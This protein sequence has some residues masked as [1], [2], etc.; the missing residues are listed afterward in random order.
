MRATTKVDLRMG[1]RPYYPELA[2]LGEALANDLKSGIP[3]YSPID[4]ANWAKR[5]G[6]GLI[7]NNA[8]SAMIRLNR[9]PSLEVLVKLGYLMRQAGA[10]VQIY[11]YLLI[12][13]DGIWAKMAKD[14]ESDEVPSHTG[15]AAPHKADVGFS[16]DYVA[17][18]YADMPW[19]DRLA[20][21][22]PLLESIQRDARFFGMTDD[23]DRIRELVKDA[24][25]THQTIGAFAAR[26]DV[27]Y[28]WVKNILDGRWD[29]V[30]VDATVGMVLKLADKVKNLDGKTG[31]AEFFAPLLTKDLHREYRKEA[32]KGLK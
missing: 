15:S 27:P 26:A 21:M 17:R 7:D 24:F 14:L 18:T 19:L 9:M 4:A 30:R 6:Q 20:A 23:L 25:H 10:D 2:G 32:K 13:A 1:N 16:V 31:D 11:D 12:A 28:E 29:E 5:F 8:I 22:Q 3:G